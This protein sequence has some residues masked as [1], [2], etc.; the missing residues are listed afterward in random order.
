M[1]QTIE[2][3]GLEEYVRVYTDES[4]MEG[5]VV[6]A[7]ICEAREIQIR[8]PKQMSIFNAEAVAILEPTKAT[9]RWGIAKKII[10]TDSLSNL[11]V[12][13]KIHTRGNSKIAELKDLLAEEKANLKI[14]CIPAHTEVP[15]QSRLTG[16]LPLG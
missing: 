13:E 3:E 11:M 1:E 9:R 5:R 12:Q 6:C 10:L 4:L 8:L 7:T 2:E 15:T 14:M 16:L